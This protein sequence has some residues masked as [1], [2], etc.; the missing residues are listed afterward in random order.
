MAGVFE[1]VQLSWKGKDYAIAA[2]NVL[3]AIQKLEDVLTLGELATSMSKGR[4]PL[5]KLSAAFGILLRH[6]GAEV[7]NEEVYSA[8]FADAGKHLQQQAFAAALTLHKLMVP[9]EHLRAAPGKPAAAPQRAG[10]SR[11]STSSRSGKR[12]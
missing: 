9:P 8:M 10:S 3:L 12:G 5:G 7:S 11:S 4:L 6:A 1:E 2:D